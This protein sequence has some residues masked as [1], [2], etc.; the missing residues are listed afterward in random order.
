MINIAMAAERERK[1]EIRKM[2]AWLRENISY[3]P[4]S[5]EMTRKTSGHGRRSGQR[6][7]GLDKRYGYVRIRCGKFGKLKR[8]RIAYAMYWGHLP[9]PQCDH[10]NHNRA[11]DRIANLCEV[12]HRGN[13]QNRSDQAELPGV[14][15]RGERFQA[16][17]SVDGEFRYIGIYDTPEEASAAYQSAVAEL[18]ERTPGASP[19]AT[20][21]TLSRGD[22]RKRLD[23]TEQQY[24]EIFGIAELE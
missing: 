11:D 10:I 24:L 4:H 19:F 13:Q 21:L 23:L 9:T 2:L 18:N 7:G 8:S 16:R 15:P 20:A 12:T 22:H 5:G 17:I 1:R 14:Q 3:D 6:A